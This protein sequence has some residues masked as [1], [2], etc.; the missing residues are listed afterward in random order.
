MVPSLPWLHC[1]LVEVLKQANNHQ[2]QLLGIC[3][4]ALTS[5]LKSYRD[6][7]LQSVA[8]F[9]MG[10]LRFGSSCDSIIFH[11]SGTIFLF[12]SFGLFQT[13]SLKFCR[14][15]NRFLSSF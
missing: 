15:Y 13:S 11:M 12:L 6:L 5:V 4:R 14:S 1:I 7:S 2:F 10:L 9:D 8:S 3:E